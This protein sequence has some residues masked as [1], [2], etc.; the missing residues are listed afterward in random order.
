[1]SSKNLN[2]CTLH[3]CVIAKEI[4]FK[5]LLD[6]G[7][8]WLGVTEQQKSKDLDSITLSTPTKH[9]SAQLPIKVGPKLA[10]TTSLLY[11]ASLCPR[12]FLSPINTRTLVYDWQHIE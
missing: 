1:M 2:F 5:R 11:M 10:S 6:L 12:N 8:V 7:Y 9:W 4:P 3:V